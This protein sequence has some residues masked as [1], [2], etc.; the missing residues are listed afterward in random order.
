MKKLP[1]HLEWQNRA[2]CAGQDTDVFFKDSGIKKAKEFCDICPVQDACLAY[3]VK[4][5]IDHGIWGGLTPGQRIGVKGKW[6]RPGEPIPH[7][8]Y[9]GY[10]THKRRGEQACEACLIANNQYSADRALAR[11]TA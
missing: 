10:R 4:E 2:A 7:G 6:G 9:N 3:A 5:H 8:T 11:R 1:E